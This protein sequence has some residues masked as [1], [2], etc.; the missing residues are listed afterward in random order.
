MILAILQARTSSSRLPGKVLLPILG[1]PMLLRQLERI[2]RARRVD[3]ILVATSV[4]ASDDELAAV[5]QEAGVAVF[6][7]ALD[8]VLDRFH[9]AA[10]TVQADH[11]VRLTG[12]CPLADPAVI[13]HMIDEHLRS[14]ADYTS[15]SLQRS[16]PD[17]L[18]VEVMRMAALTEAWRIAR[19]PSER[20]HVTPRLHHEPFRRHA[21]VYAED[22]AK[23]RWVVDHA[24]DLAVIRAVYERLYPGNPDFRMAEVL[25]LQRREPALFEPSQGFDPDEGWRRSLAQDAAWLRD[26]ERR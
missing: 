19:L 26:E 13:D 7:G 25:A 20:E 4:D 2:A 9:A 18:D 8:D 3:R 1:R 17:G 23:L 5:V 12:D 22:L 15:N 10:S 21:V 14:G 6:R 16:Y 24:A 11:V